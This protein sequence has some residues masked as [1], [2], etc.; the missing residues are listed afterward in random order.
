[1][2]LRF[3]A[4]GLGVGDRL[5]LGVG[6]SWNDVEIDCGC[7]VFVE[8]D[9]AGDL[10]QWTNGG[11]GFGVGT[12]GC[13]GRGCVLGRDGRDTSVDLSFGLLRCPILLLRHPV[14]LWERR[15][16]AFGFFARRC[17]NLG[18]FRRCEC[19][20]VVIAV[21]YLYKCLPVMVYYP[22]III[23]PLQIVSIIS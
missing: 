16:D 18:A 2:R 7:A 19:I 1:M 21:F 4:G 9:A 6:Q 20:I 3:L 10:R 14:G 17:L 22:L 8:H 13:G 5:L 11:G 12:A 15:F 23:L